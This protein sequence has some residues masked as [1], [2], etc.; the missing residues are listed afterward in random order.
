MSPQ[1]ESVTPPARCDVLVIGAGLA[2]VSVASLVA[3][4]LPSARVV[5]VERRTQPVQSSPAEP[6]SALASLFFSRVLGAEE[7]L[8]REQLPITGTHAWFATQVHDVLSEMVELGWDAGGPRPAHHVDGARLARALARRAAGPGVEFVYGT[9]AQTLDLHW[10]ESRV[11]LRD[12]RGTR[13][14]RARWVVDASGPAALL[15][16]EL[17]LR[18]CLDTPAAWSAGANWAGLRDLDDAC[19]AGL[20]RSERASPWTRSRQFATQ[21]FCGDRWHVRLCPHPAGGSSV[22]LLAQRGASRDEGGLRSLESYSRFVRSRPGLRELLRG[23]RLDPHSFE[24]SALHDW[25]VSRRCARGWWLVGDAGGSL[26]S[27]FASPLDRLVRDVQAAAGTILGDV[28]GA[29]SEQETLAELEAHEACGRAR[30]ACESTE[31][32][33]ALAGLGGD[34]AITGAYLRLRC[35]FEE[36]ELRRAARDPHALDASACDALWRGSLRSAWLARLCH[37]ASARRAA[38]ISTEFK[39]LR[40]LRLDGS[41]GGLT[42]GALALWWWLRL[43]YGVT[44]EGLRPVPGDEHTSAV[45]EIACRAAC[46][47]ERLAAFRAGLAP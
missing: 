4:R 33:G 22:R 27:A 32:F 21:H 45:V 30:D 46:A 47:H 7:L 14:L 5:V 16:K 20:A 12:G 37:L 31:I 17:S 29:A 6:L 38:G 23:A 11:Q 35:A 42:G 15:A 28:A 43:E 9:R 3:R 44:R 34:A 13:E 41:Q 18:R 10:P 24:S 8:V 40:V 36:R 26:H 39:S 1:P 2:G 19:A 25:T